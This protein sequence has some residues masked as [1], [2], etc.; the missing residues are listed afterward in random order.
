MSLL[1]FLRI[2]FARRAIIIAAALSCFI[3]ASATAFMLP[4]SYT[5]TSQLILGQGDPLAQDEKN[6][7]AAKSDNA[8]QIQLIKDYRTAGRVVDA[9]GWTRDPGSIARY[10]AS[11]DP[12]QIDI[13]RWLAQTIIDNTTAGM[14]GGTSMVAF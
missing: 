9:L 6:G 8:T 10:N 13:R 1:Q 3:V 11:V 2:L 12:T 4:K 7:R 5:A 14:V